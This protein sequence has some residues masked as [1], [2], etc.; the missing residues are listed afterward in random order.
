MYVYNRGVYARR[1]CKC[2]LQV[3]LDDEWDRLGLQACPRCDAVWP[4]ACRMRAPGDGGP[5]ITPW[6]DKL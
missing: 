2:G 4:E 3:P 6:V 1:V 5:F